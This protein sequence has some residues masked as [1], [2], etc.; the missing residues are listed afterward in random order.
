VDTYSPSGRSEIRWRISCSESA[1]LIRQYSRCC[2]SPCCSIT[3]ESRCWPTLRLAI[4]ERMSFSTGTG[5]RTLA[6]MN[7][8]Q[9]LLIRPL[10]TKRVAGK[11]SAS[12]KQSRA[13]GANPDTDAPPTSSRCSLT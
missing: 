1:L 4:I 6:A 2:S 13:S 11:R 9:S 10:R 8:A 7:S 3:R 12:E 5:T